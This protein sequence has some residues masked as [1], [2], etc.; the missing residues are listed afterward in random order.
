[1]SSSSYFAKLVDVLVQINIHLQVPM[2]LDISGAGGIGITDIMTECHRLHFATEMGITDGH[3]D[4][5]VNIMHPPSIMQFH[6]IFYSLFLNPTLHTGSLSY[7][8]IVV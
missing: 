2:F 3:A 5:Q 7:D 4:D 8:M 1:M 6:L